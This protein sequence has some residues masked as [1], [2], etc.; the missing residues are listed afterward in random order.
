MTTM[1]RPEYQFLHST[2]RKNDHG[3][4]IVANLKNV[5]TNV[6]KLSIVSNPDRKVWIAKK[7]LWETYSEK[8]EYSKLSDVDEFIVPNWQLLEKLKGL[9]G[10]KADRYVN[11][12]VLLNDHRL[13]GAD[14]DIEVLMKQYYMHS[15][16]KVATN[17]RVGGLDI[18]TSVLGGN[19]V[20]LNTYVT[21]EHKVFTAVL[22]PF[23]KGRTEQDILECVDISLKKFREELNPMAQAIYD[24]YPPEIKLFITNSE[25]EVMTWIFEQIHREKDDFISIWNMGYDI[26]FILD[27]LQFHNIDWA[28]AMCHPEVPKEARVCKWEPDRTKK[29]THWSHRWDF[30]HLSGYSQFI[31][32]MC[33]YS[34]LRK[35]EGI[36]S[37]YALKYIADKILGT[38]KLDFGEAGHPEMQKN[39]FVEYTAYNI[40]DALLLPLLDKVTGDIGSLLLLTEN[41][42]LPSFSKQTVQLKNWFFDYCKSVGCVPASCYKDQSRPTDQYVHNTGGGVL[43][44][45]LAKGTGVAKI[46][47][48][49]EPT[50]L[51]VMVSDIDVVSQYPHLL[52]MS[53]VSK[54]TKLST[55]L[56]MQGR[57]YEDIND[58]FGHY[59]ATFENS[60]Y[61]GNKFFGLPSYEEM[62]LKVRNRNNA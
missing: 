29:L 7:G 38:S 6:S 28:R 39:R 45:S 21:H 56:E 30:F 9:L 57:P 47:E 58:F 16:D 42:D 55:V 62:T 19:E 36:E 52:I 54:E 3:D 11:K 43:S 35:I 20:I 50:S 44:P 33:L 15:T 17:I 4:F 31:D 60:V 24:K 10:Y 49:D 18:E 26:P 23:L 59:V 12:T 27:R 61:L 53:N 32:S 13:F 37:S 51:C 1:G 41:T 2:Y 14:I 46:L 25:V 40:V 22:A 5:D 48:T 34:R 8:K